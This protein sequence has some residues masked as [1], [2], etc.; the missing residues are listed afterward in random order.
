M[1]I[2]SG[3]K[4]QSVFV[5][6]EFDDRTLGKFSMSETGRVLTA[7]NDLFDDIGRISSPPTIAPEISPRIAIV[8][9]EMRSPLKVKIAIAGLSKE[10]V[11]A[12]VGLLRDVMFYRET[13]RQRAAIAAKEWEE[14]A[15]QRLA[16]IGK[17]LDLALRA[18][19]ANKLVTEQEALRIYR[20]VLTLEQVDMPLKRAEII[21]E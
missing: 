7:I 1:P 21:K 10:A 9:M 16:N 12:V 19:G 20:N 13:K 17:A 11:Q 4:T 14:V 5:Q 2:A 8:S 6:T 18:N 3:A 15:S